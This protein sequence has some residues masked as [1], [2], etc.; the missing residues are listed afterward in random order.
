MPDEK[1]SGEHSLSLGLLLA[2]F[3]CGTDEAAMA[4]AEGKNRDDSKHVG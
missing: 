2:S 1:L 3:T 4:V